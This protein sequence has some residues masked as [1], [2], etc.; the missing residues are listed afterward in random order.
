MATIRSRKRADGTVSYTVQIRI[1]KDGKQAYNETQT[2][3]RRKAAEVWA[4]RRETELS[5]PGAIERARHGGVLLKDII[6]KYLN[7][8]GQAAP[9]GKTKEATLR[10]IARSSL[11]ELTAAQVTSQALVDYA[12][13]RMGP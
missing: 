9:L 11:G 10:A 8:A 12:L 3:A 5:E 2:F 6:E 4:K 7:E 13:W 1:Q